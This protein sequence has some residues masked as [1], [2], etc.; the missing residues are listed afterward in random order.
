[1]EETTIPSLTQLGI[2]QENVL[3]NYSIDSHNY[4]VYVLITFERVGDSYQ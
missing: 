2:Q 3:C 4:Q 1:M